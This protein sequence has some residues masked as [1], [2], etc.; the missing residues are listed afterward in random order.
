MKLFCT[1]FCMF[2]RKICY[3]GIAKLDL[4]GTFRCQTENVPRIFKNNRK[5]NSE[6]LLR[7]IVYI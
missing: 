7:F 6:Q 3:I 1:D 4:F 2:F 5:K